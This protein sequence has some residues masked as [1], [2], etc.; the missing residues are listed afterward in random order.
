MEPTTMVF[1]QVSARR[2]ATLGY[3]PWMFSVTMIEV[4]ESSIWRAISR[5]AYMRIVV[6]HGA[7]G[8]EHGEEADHVIGA[9]R[10]EQADP[11]ALPDAERLKALGRPI[12]QLAD[13]LVARL[14]AEEVETAPVRPGGDGVVEH[15]EQRARGDVEIPGEAFA[16]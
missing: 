14:A 5:S 10:Q 13:L 4:L 9:V 1:R 7:A 16:G 6:D 12:D 11:H 8:L 15:T 3:M 2:R